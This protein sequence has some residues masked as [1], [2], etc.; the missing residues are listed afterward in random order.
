MKLSPYNDLTKRR[1][2]VLKH[3]FNLPERWWEVYGDLFS[4]NKDWNS[5]RGEGCFN[6]PDGH[7]AVAESNTAQT[8]LD[9][10]HE[11]WLAA[12]ERACDE[13]RARHTVY[14]DG[15][16][17]RVCY[18]GADGVFVVATDRA[19]LVT[20]YRPGRGHPMSGEERAARVAEKTAAKRLSTTNDRAA[21]RRGHQRASLNAAASRRSED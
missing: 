11:R 7:S 6:G 18:V 16:A 15:K 19:I 21:V 20:C 3:V 17:H 14:P 10:H 13:A 4:W 5:L 12:A 2:K 1:K 8:L 9:Q